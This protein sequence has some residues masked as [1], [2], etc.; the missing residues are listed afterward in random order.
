MDCTPVRCVGCGYS[1]QNSDQ[2]STKTCCIKDFRPLIPVYIDYDLRHLSTLHAI[3]RR[4]QHALIKSFFVVFASVATNVYTIFVLP[5][6]FLN[7]NR[8]S[9]E[10][11]VFYVLI[12]REETEFF[13][14]CNHLFSSQK[15]IFIRDEQ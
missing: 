13:N 12:T 2:Y 4:L 5:S 7:F 11:Y 9:H 14:K 6:Y 15:N 10:L 8:I 3:W 1:N